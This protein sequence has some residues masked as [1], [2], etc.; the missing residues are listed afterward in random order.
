[1]GLD[2]GYFC[3]SQLITVCQDVADSLDEGVG[4]NAIIIDFS[5]GIPF[6]SRTAAMQES[7]SNFSLKGA[8]W[9]H[10]CLYCS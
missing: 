8:F 5:K 4:I 1:M 3:E 9:A 10:Y 6:Q 7:Q 2:L